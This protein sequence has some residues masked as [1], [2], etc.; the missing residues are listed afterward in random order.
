MVLECHHMYVQK[1]ILAIGQVSLSCMTWKQEIMRINSNLC[2]QTKTNPYLCQ[3]F[4]SFLNIFSLAVS[5]I[6]LVFDG[7]GDGDASMSTPGF[8]ALE[9]DV[10]DAEA[11]YEKTT[12]V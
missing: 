7:D 10:T 4:V 2:L 9:A 1:I 6:W 12:I 8:D 11:N 5:N 3:D